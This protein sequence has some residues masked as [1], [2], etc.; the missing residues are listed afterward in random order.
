ML[1]GASQ[2]SCR[3]SPVGLQF[4]TKFTTAHAK[5]DGKST[6]QHLDLPSPNDIDTI[7]KLLDQAT[8]TY[9]HKDL[10]RHCEE[11][12]R[13]TYVEVREHTNAISRGLLSAR[14]FPGKTFAV[15][16]QNDTENFLVRLGA[17]KI[18]VQIAHLNV[19]SLTK[20]NIL[21]EFYE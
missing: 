8:E 7:G 5:N 11:S 16:L 10:F 20:E 13:L 1:K 9:T 3:L 4:R 15:S 6:L 21:K 17:N 19:N 12:D 18:G 14:V 2:F